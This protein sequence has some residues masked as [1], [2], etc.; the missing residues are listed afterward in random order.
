M[1]NVRV[2]LERA[3]FDALRPFEKAAEGVAL[4]VVFPALLPIWWESL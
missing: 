2:F 1:K 4:L 3:E